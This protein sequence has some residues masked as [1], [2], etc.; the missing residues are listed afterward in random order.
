MKIDRY[1]SIFNV[2]VLEINIIN[3]IHS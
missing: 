1:N 3:I 2:L